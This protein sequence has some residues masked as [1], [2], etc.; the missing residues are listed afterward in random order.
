MN[1]NI[2]RVSM[3]YSDGQLESVQV[4]FEGRNEPRTYSINGYIPLTAEEYKGNEAVPA[5]EALVRSQVAEKIM[6]GK[7]E[8]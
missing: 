5:L 4:H 8:E 3:Q 7:S 6:E 2:S 1:I